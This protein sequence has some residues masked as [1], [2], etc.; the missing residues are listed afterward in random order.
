MN[1]VIKEV[2]EE[3]VGTEK[4]VSP[5]TIL[6]ISL[7]VLVILVFFI[8]KDMD[9]IR[10]FIADSGWVGI[11]VAILLYGLLGISPIPSEPLTILLSTI[12]GPLN[13]TLASG[14]G[15]LLASLVEYYIGA[16]IGHAANFQKR[17][18]KLPFGL[19]KLPVDSALFLLGA[20]MIPG[21]GPKL[22]SLI[23]GVYR[24]P[25]YRYIWTAAIPTFLG[26]AIFAYGGSGLFSLRGW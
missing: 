21:Y 8:S 15:N 16:T 3:I 2:E 9:K 18:E 24:V 12:F 22:V 4:K 5:V 7:M 17:K 14:L 19:G 26:A 6:V 13:A 11:V 23:G 25:L 20:R 10:L 1:K